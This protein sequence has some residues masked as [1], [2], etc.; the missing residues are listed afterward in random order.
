MKKLLVILA[1]VVAA[2]VMAAVLT[3]TWNNAL[4]N[5]DG[6]PIPTSGPG[7]IVSTKI[8]YGTCNL[9]AFGTKLGEFTANY[10]ATSTA[11]PNLGPGTY[12]FRAIHTNTYGE[13]SDPSNV[14]SRTVQ[15]PKPNP[16][17]LTGVSL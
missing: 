6:S 13:V 17:V 2:P 10:P 15:A 14:I 12:C 7:S 16:P 8:E 3:A 4:S 11:T 5:V 9:T 1:L